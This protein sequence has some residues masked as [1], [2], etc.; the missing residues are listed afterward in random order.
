MGKIIPFSVWI[1]PFPVLKIYF[2]LFGNYEVDVLKEVVLIRGLEVE[3]IIPIPILKINFELLGGNEKIFVKEVSQ[4]EDW[5]W[6]K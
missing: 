6:E 5:K 1:I 2:E 4:S 3:E